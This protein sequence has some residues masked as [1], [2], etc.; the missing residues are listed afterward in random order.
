MF[1]HA[2]KFDQDLTKW[3]TKNLSNNTFKFSNISLENLPFG[4]AWKL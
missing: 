3:N 1:S 4:K 2:S